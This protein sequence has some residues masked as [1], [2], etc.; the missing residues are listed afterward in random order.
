[1]PD[2]PFL[3]SLYRILQKMALR[4]DKCNSIVDVVRAMITVETS[5][6]FSEV[7]KYLETESG[8]IIVDVKSRSRRSSTRRKKTTPSSSKLR[9]SR[10]RRRLPR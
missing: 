10:R 5:E 6:Q 7:L 3:K 2:K 4:G 9:P 8:T 1:V